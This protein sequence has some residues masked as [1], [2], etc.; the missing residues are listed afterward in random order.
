MPPRYRPDEEEMRK[1][2]WG[3]LGTIFLELERVSEAGSLPE[4]LEAATADETN[5]LGIAREHEVATSLLA[6]L[7]RE[8]IAMHAR[9]LEAVRERERELSRDAG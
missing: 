2:A 9:S 6:G 8:I 5:F 7:A 1:E 3:M 4:N